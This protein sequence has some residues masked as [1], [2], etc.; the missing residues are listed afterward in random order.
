MKKFFL[1]LC[2]TVP[3]QLTLKLN[4]LETRIITCQKE[5]LFFNTTVL[6][7]LGHKLR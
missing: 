2:K 5:D 3:R 4:L 7:L 1:I 6:I